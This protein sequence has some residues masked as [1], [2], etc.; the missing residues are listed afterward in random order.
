[1]T[2]L[3]VRARDGF[4]LA[5][6]ARGPLDAPVLL[7]LAGQANSHTWWDAVRPGFED[8]FRTVTLDQRGTGASRGPVGAWSTASFADDAADVLAG[9]GVA[10]AAV[11]GTSMGG[12]VAQVLASG[13]PDLVDRLVLACTSPGGPHAVER[14]PEV[15]RALADPDRERRRRVLH[16][17]F[18][19]PAWPHPPER[20][21]L[22][23]DPTM[24]AEESRAHLRVSAR[25]DAWES[26]PDIT[27]PTLVLHGGD[28]LMTPAVNASLI[29]G[30][31]P[32]AVLE[33]LDGRHGFFEEHA[34][35][36]TPRVVDFLGG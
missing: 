21:T 36:V 16:D 4:D 8:R 22:L 32:G 29:A 10:R 28:D 30:R 34:D 3:V 9:L 11:Y 2:A 1:M 19:T 31:V 15:R 25:H 17:L 12:R 23:G 7:L 20:S 13:R 33:V 18:Y 5:V 35:A 26:L 27:S 24:T 14:G 6:Q